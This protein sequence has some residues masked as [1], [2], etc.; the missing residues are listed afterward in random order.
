MLH[1]SNS[2]SCKSPWIQT[3][4]LGKSSGALMLLHYGNA[5]TIHLSKDTGFSDPRITVCA[6]WRS[7]TSPQ[8]ACGHLALYLRWHYLSKPGNTAEIKKVHMQVG[9]SR[10]MW[11]TYLVV[12]PQFSARCFGCGNYPWDFPIPDPGTQKA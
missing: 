4:R 9:I 1:G 6:P 8:R 12:G 5:L 10:Y 7:L 11:N 2:R 3:P